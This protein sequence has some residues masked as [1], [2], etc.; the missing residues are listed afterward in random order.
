MNNPYC[1]LPKA[2]VVDVICLLTTVEKE[3]KGGKCFVYLR[4]GCLHVYCFIW[5]TPIWMLLC[6]SKVSTLSGEGGDHIIYALH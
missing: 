4:V 1:V 2:I 6:W 3:R 5:P